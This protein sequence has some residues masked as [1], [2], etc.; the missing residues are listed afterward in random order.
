M[1]DT[2]TDLKVALR[3]PRSRNGTAA[4]VIAKNKKVDIIAARADS[5]A[6]GGASSSRAGVFQGT[7]AS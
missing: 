6:Y 7:A 1:S 4:T 5:A 3:S 2:T